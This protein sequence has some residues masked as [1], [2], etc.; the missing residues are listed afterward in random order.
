[1]SEQ[2]PEPEPQEP[3]DPSTQESDRSTSEPETD[4]PEPFSLEEPVY[5]TIEKGDKHDYETR[6]S[7][8]ETKDSESD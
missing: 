3:R 8:I 1:M 5:D 2:T 6:E 4:Q 7:E